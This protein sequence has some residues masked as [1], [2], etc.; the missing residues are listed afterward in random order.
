MFT[1]SLQTRTEVLTVE[2]MHDRIEKH[3]VS[4]VD[5]LVRK[6]KS[7]GPLLTIIELHVCE[8]ETGCSELL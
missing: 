1:L 5:D 6:Y 4:V 8:T 2:E 3:R 7:I